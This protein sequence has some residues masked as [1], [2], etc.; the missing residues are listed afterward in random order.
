MMLWAVRAVWLRLTTT[1]MEVRL[2]GMTD[3]PSAHSL[4]QSDQR[5]LG[6]LAPLDGR[7]STRQSQAMR[8][9]DHSVSGDGKF[10]GDLRSGEPL[11]PQLPQTGLEG[12]GPNGAHV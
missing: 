10:S 6:C 8:F 11:S 3:R 2:T 1:E 5:Q 7:R 9:A 12:I 4:L